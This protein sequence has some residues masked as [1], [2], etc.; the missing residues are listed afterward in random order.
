MQKQAKVAVILSGCGVFDG[1]EIHESVLTLLALARAGAKVTCAAPDI[2]Q[3]HVINHATGEIA[4]DE[5]RNVLEEAA[6]ISRGEIK[7]INELRLS[8][9]DAI[10]FVGGFG[11]AKNLSS[12]AFDGKAYD[13]DPIIHSFIQEAHQ[14][15]KALGFMCIAPALAA[16]ALG[17]NQVRLTIG[18]DSDTAAIL[19]S[20][21]AQHINCSVNEIVVDT[22][23]RVVTTPAY[24]LAEDILQAEAG[25]NKLITEL[26]KL[27]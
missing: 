13:I 21:G 1:A 23:N 12:L 7:R 16:S 11:V 9:L 14:A 25:I 4:E 3:R 5:D 17:A 20:K 6:R 24:M 27:I 2:T 10:I 19:E 26:L 8:E 18:N 22:T 15:H